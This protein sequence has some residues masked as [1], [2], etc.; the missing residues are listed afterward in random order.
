MLSA[1][2]VCKISEKEVYT[3]PILFARGMIA[4]KR[5]SFVIMGPSSDAVKNVRCLGS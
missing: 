2:F 1:L 5:D 3:E 4:L